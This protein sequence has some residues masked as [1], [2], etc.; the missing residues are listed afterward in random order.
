[1]I[2]QVSNRIR[3]IFF[4]T[5]LIFAVRMPAYSFPKLLS[6][7][8][9]KFQSMLRSLPDTGNNETLLSIDKPVLISD[10]FSFTEGP[11]VDK[12]GNVFFTDQPNNKIWKYDVKGKLTL[13]M[14]NAKRS[15]GLFFDAKGN[16]VSCA[17]EQNQLVS[18]DRFGKKIM[19]LTNKFEGGNFNGPND[20]WVNHHNGNIYFT[21]PYYKRDYWPKDHTHIEEQ[22]VYL[23]PKGKKNAVIADSSLKK[24][25]GIV[26]SANGKLLFVADIEG[27]KIYKFDIDEEG[28]LT[29]K[30]VFVNQGSDGMTLDNQ[31][32]LY[33]CGK[34]VTV[35]NSK[36]KQ[37]QHFNI[38]ED[39]TAN[40]CFGGKNNNIL[41]ITASKS[42]YIIHMKVKGI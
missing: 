37:I 25:N 9:I 42:I 6:I 32:N 41:F 14:D 35:Y 2:K 18:I 15:N 23:L 31:G 30:T 21:D 26:G 7:K 36:G 10:Q 38:P 3:R 20:V 28:K 19:V 16:I 33:L 40:V 1:M 12:E 24:P 4:I 22:R 29:N 11:A 27:S 13:F 17:D 5:G 34:G 39:W 8:Y